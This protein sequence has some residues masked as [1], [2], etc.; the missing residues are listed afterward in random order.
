VQKKKVGDLAALRELLWFWLVQVR[1]TMELSIVP[2]GI[3]DTLSY[4][5]FL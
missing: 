3:P 2:Y 5:R 1:K 4:N